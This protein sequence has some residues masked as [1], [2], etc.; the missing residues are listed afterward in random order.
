MNPALANHRCH[1]SA[2]ILRRW[3]AVGRAAKLRCEVIYQTP[4]G[5]PVLFFSTRVQSAAGLYFSAGV[6]GDEAAPVTALLEWAEG[7]IALLQR[8]SF[9]LVPLFNPAGLQANTRADEHGQDL[10][11]CFQDAAH[12][13]LAGWHRAMLGRRFRAAVML[14]EDYDAQGVY[15]YELSGL[16]GKSALSCEPML[17]AAAAWIPRDLR[18]KIDGFSA[19]QGVIR[20][21]VVPGAMPGLPEALVLRQEYAA[22]TFTFETPSEF[23][24]LER[25]AAHR[26]I[27]D[28]VVA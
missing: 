4:A 1:D 20:P 8:E 13:H 11:R 14:H 6:H 5:F 24:L 23:G 15:A 9:V 10:N 16:N 7:N 17:E 18:R 2:A 26:A 27:L 19:R 12:P 21:R 28:Q 22:A 25:V 3:R